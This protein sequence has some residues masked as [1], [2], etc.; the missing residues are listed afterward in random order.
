MK[1]KL[2]DKYSMFV[3][4]FL[5]SIILTLEI[6]FSQGII[7]IIPFLIIRFFILCRKN[8]KMV[9]TDTTLW[10]LMMLFL[11]T[12]NGLRVIDNDE[13]FSVIYNLVAFIC[14]ILIQM[15]MHFYHNVIDLI[16]PM[17]VITTILSGGIIFVKEYGMLK[18]RWTDFLI[19]N[20]GYR[21]GVSSGINPNMI[22]WTF[23]FLALLSLFLFATEKKVRYISVYAIDLIVVFFTGSKNGLFLAIIPL[24]I[25]AIKALRKVNIKTL[26]LI[27]VL[28]LMIWFIIHR[29]P[30]LYTLVGKRIDSMLYTLGLFNNVKN[31]SV[32][33]DIGST[34][35]R[36]DMISVAEGMFWKHPILGWGIG[37]FAKYSGYGYY[38]HNNYMEILVS[39]GIIGF[40]LYYCYLIYES[41][42]LLKMKNGIKKD[43]AI[44][45]FMSLFFLD[46]STVNFYSHIALYIRTILLVEIIKLKYE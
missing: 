31:S 19:G 2:D 45:L 37:A 10:L 7:I 23:G 27:S 18:N 3:D 24:F 29:N 22:T 32:S 42:F 39:C 35:K 46:F 5:I 6:I 36:L 16:K 20:S 34:E 8:K 30:V 12:L 44:M 17:V 13:Q 40:L 25:Y 9:I 14:L 38:C 33:L 21:L 11:T 15:I 26:I 1:N 43:L 4:G 41:F 28:L